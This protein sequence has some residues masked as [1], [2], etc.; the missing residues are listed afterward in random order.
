MDE[1]QLLEKIT[2]SWEVDC[3]IDETELVKAQLDA[4]I[5]HC[6]YINFFHLAKKKHIDLDARYKRMLLQK[7]YSLNTKD[8]LIKTA[9][10]AKVVLDADDDLLK[11]N[12][13]IEVILLTLK[14]LESIITKLSYRV[15]DVKSIIEVK[16]FVEGLN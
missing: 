15:S 13:K 5:L 3:V 6:K 10:D 12:I 9:A 2:K 16:K 11:L 7:K 4:P 8:Y 1:E 14:T